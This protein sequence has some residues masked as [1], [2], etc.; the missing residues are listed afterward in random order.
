MKWHTPPRSTCRSVDVEKVV[1]L[2]DATTKPCT[3]PPSAQTMALRP[4][5]AASCA[6]SAAPERRE[7]P[8]LDGHCVYVD[9]ASTRTAVPSQTP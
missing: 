2:V 4:T 8:S 6:L 3:P 5:N 9:A 1:P 7:T